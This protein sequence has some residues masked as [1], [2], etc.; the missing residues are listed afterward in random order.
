MLLLSSGYEPE[1]GAW[2]YYKSLAVA[3]V[4]FAATARAPCYRVSRSM[5]SRAISRVI[6]KTPTASGIAPPFSGGTTPE[7]PG[8]EEPRGLAFDHLAKATHRLVRNAR[9]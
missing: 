6:A 7:P 2:R 1:K 8:E 5:T 3:G 9:A 4:V